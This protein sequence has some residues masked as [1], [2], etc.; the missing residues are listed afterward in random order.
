MQLFVS[1]KGYV[2]IKPT[3]SPSGFTEN[4]KEFAKEVEAKYILVTDM[5]PSQK[6]K[7]VKEFLNKIGTTLRLL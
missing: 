1:D 2:K 6:R 7:D 3:K 5:H 4:L